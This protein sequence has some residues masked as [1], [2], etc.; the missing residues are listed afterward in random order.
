MTKK[1]KTKYLCN[2][3]GY[4][5]NKWLGKCPACGVYNSLVEFEPESVNNDINLAD[6][7]K[8]FMLSEIPESKIERI[9]T[10]I[11]EF[12]NLI[13]GGLVRSSLI[14]IGGN[15]GIGK[16]T[17]TLQ[18]LAALPGKSLYIAG[19]ESPEQIKLRADRLNI[20][21]PEIS[22]YQEIEINKILKTCAELNP[23][24]LIIDS[25]QTVYN[26]QVQ[27]APGS[28][29]Q[30]RETTMRILE[31][32][33][34][35]HTVGIIIGHI[36]KTGEFAG[37][38]ALEHL[39]DTVLYFEGDKT[40]DFRILRSIK[41]RFGA[42]NEI[43]VFEMRGSGLAGVSNYANLFFYNRQEKVAGVANG[44][45]IEGSRPILIEVQALVAPA[46]YG[47]SRRISAGFNVN[48]L[49]VII[50][51]I[52]KHCQLHLIDKDIFV[53][54]TGG[55]E[56][57]EPSAD[58]AIAVAIISSI[59]N[60]PIDFKSAFIGELGLTGELRPVAR[61]NDRFRECQ[62]NGIYNCI[63]SNQNS[64]DDVSRKDI[65]ILTIGNIKEIL[66]YF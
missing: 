4:E 41:N 18:L 65:K 43:G 12:D 57:D 64:I 16:S 53:N 32:V 17:L 54:I 46:I 8:P 7:S 45:I 48:K 31:F 34:K 15:P 49:S 58:L 35:T 2:G 37:P 10:G 36:T 21:K 22:I 39:V 66:K 40:N 23:D 60:R 11:L 9:T 33:K 42:T 29:I 55:L 27:S 44:V 6:G 51:I 19:E 28:I 61:V 52:E 24:Y 47:N 62:K 26:S 5:T 14:L 20:K 30:V 3:C 25:I 13:G 1:T 50:A 63:V 38:R 59:K 56:I